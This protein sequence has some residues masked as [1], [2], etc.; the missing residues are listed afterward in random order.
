MHKLLTF[1]STK[2]LAYMTYF[3]VLNFNE[4]LTN[5]IV[6]FEQPGPGIQIDIQKSFRFL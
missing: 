4:T 2:L 6:S 1:F 5:D 3:N